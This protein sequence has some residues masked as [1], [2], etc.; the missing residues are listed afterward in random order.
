MGSMTMFFPAQDVGDLGIGP[1]GTQHRHDH[2][3]SGDH[4]DRPGNS[5]ASPHGELPT[6]QCVA[7][8][9]TLQVDEHPVVTKAPNH[10]LEPANLGESG[11][12]AFEE[13]H[14]NG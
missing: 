9:V 13:N 1:H 8:A 11:S 10:L 14:R 2:R 12:G 6:N 5:S 7:I 3:R 4:H